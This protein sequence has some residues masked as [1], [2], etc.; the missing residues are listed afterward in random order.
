MIDWTPL[1]GATKLSNDGLLTYE[2]PFFPDS[3]RVACPHITSPVCHG[4]AN[5]GELCRPC[6]GR[7]W[8]AETDGW[9][10]WRETAQ[11]GEWVNLLGG[12]D[13]KGF[14][15]ECSFGQ[16]CSAS[17]TDPE[18]ALNAALEQAVLAAGGTLYA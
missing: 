15:A 2:V 3:V 18:A 13:V 6:Q 12:T 11:I 5:V 16:T 1:A 17:G 7:G 14:E 8:V 10:W 9:V 4:S